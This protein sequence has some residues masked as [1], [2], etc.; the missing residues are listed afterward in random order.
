MKIPMRVRSAYMLA[1]VGA[2]AVLPAAVVVRTVNPTWEVVVADD[3]MAPPADAN[4]APEIQRRL[5]ALGATGGG[6]L[7]LK[8]GTYRIASSVTL[9]INTCLKGDYDP[10]APAKSTVLSIVAGRGDENGE[11]TFRMG[12]SSALQGLFFHYPEQTLDNPVPYP[13][14]VRAKQHPRRAPDHQTI[15]D[16]TFVNAWQAIAIGPEPNELH[17]FRDVRICAL[18]TGFAVDSTTDIG[19][20]IDM[21]V[22]PRA[23]SASGLPGAPD[24]RLLRD[25][26]KTHDTLGAWYGR[27]DW[28]YVWR[29]KVDG[30]RTGCRFTQGKRGTSNAVMDESTFTDCATG[31]EV[32]HV[33]G[34]GLAVYD[35]RFDGCARSASMT[36]NFTTVVQFLACSFGGK[37]PVNEGKSL[38]NVIVKDG[39]GEPVRHQPMTWPR[40]ASDRLLVATDFGLA[41]NGE[42]NASALQ[43]ALDAAKGGGTVYVPAGMY[44]F[45]RPVSVP[46]G[47]ELR[48]SSSAP[49]HTAA[50]GSVLLVRYGKGDEDGAPFISLARGAGL[51]GVLVWYPE[52]PILDPV[53]YPWAVRSLG[54][55]TW[56]ADV[57]IAN[58]WRGADFATCPSGGHRIAYLSGVAW[59]KML[60][61]GNSS[62]RGWVEETLFNPHYSQRLSFNLPNV[63][64]KR[65]EGCSAGGNNIPVQS[66]NMRRRLEAHVF[67]DCADERIRGTF[68]YAAKDGMTFRGK[69]KATVVMHG[70]D[71]IARGVELEQAEGGHVDAALVQVTPYET[72]SGK[73]SAGFHFASGDRGTAVFRASQLWVPKPSVIAE[74]NGLGVFEMANSLSG[75]VVARTGRLELEDFRFSSSLE[76]FL[77]K[78]SAADVRA[79]RTG[80][81]PMPESLCPKAPP[82]DVS[83]DCEATR[84]MENVVARWGGV[85]GQG[86]W[87]CGAKDGEL[88]FR[89]ELKDPKYAYVYAD[90]WKGE[91]PVW[92]T[93]RLKYRMNPADEKSAGTVTLDLAFSDGTQARVLRGLPVGKRLPPGEWTDVSIPL[94][95]YTGKT[96]VRI[97]VRADRRF[98]PGLYEARLD[99]IR[100]VTPR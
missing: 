24:E 33:N 41:T 1:V 40:P 96:I 78:T 70:A 3:V 69:N 91:S 79:V 67:T 9:P 28:E 99:D 51:R 88:L 45:K 76:E 34:V 35:T 39:N 85:R 54:E 92:P 65:P 58:A 55:D 74:G 90:V 43:R 82:M 68:V 100:I 61:V 87:F 26:L 89:A 60:V 20:V 81:F 97:M 7:F 16:C 50:G 42:D 44:S 46:T 22:S 48:G 72:A 21:V 11:P 37:P 27:S 95:C 63:Q 13:W 2:W 12:T 25:W 5:D 52:N 47:V 10:S 29:L 86:E 73:E 6:T 62:R 4:A 15:R 84:P 53:P 93:T 32:D 30:Y 23:W 71:T 66:W 31:L 80:E 19:R 94:R 8:A 49:H 75:P 14:T 57:C 83:I 56:L 17:T 18:K 77:Q 64:G 98:A 38:S 36:T 59:Q